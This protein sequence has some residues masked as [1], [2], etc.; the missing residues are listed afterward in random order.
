MI[1][2]APVVF[3]YDYVDHANHGEVMF[4]VQYNDVK[5]I[6]SRYEEYHPTHTIAQL[7]WDDYFLNDVKPA[8]VK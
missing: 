6:I 8:M 4:W 2:L 1:A 5:P 7:I 3:V